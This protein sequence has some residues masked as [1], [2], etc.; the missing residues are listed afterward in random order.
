[1]SRRKLIWK[2]LPSYLS[3]VAIT[4]AVMLW[5]ANRT[6]RSLI[7]D[8][9]RAE[10]FEMGGLIRTG[11]L[12]ANRKGGME[13]LKAELVRQ[14]EA[15]ENIR[16]TV[17]LPSGRVILDTY[18]DVEM[19]DNHANRPEIQAAF[20]GQVG[21]EIRYSNT[22]KQEMLYV[23]LPCMESGH[24]LAVCRLS[25]PLALIARTRHDAF[26]RI[27]WGAFAAALVA[28]CF[29]LWISRHITAPIQEMQRVAARLAEGEFSAR[30]RLP[31]TRELAAL[32]GTMNTMAAELS[33]RIQTVTRQHNEL[34]ALLTSMVEG[35]LA[36]DDETRILIMNHAAAGML[37][38]TPETVIG[39]SIHETIRY[40]GLH[41]IFQSAIKTQSPAEGEITLQLDEAEIV[42]QVHAS[43]LAIPV[44]DRDGNRRGV[45]L[46][47]NDI[48]R[49]KRLENLRRDFA[50]NVSHELRTPI[51]SIKGFVETLRDGAMHDPEAAGRF[52]DIILAQTDRLNALISD[53]LSLAEIEQDTGNR[54]AELKTM[55][56]RPRLEAAIQAR[57]RKAEEAEITV[58]LTCPEELVATLNPV[59]FEQAV[60]NLIGNAIAYSDRGSA[61]SVTVE[62]GTDGIRIAV[63]DHGCGIEA[64]HIDRLFER[65]YRVDKHRSREKGGTGLGLAIVK[66]VVQLHKG[67]VEVDST[68]GKGSTF[69][70]ILPLP[71]ASQ[72]PENGSG[73]PRSEA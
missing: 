67:R 50:A 63:K 34:D 1:M 24:L 2:I 55:E 19:M 41:R 65:F 32:A 23:A 40:P 66:H 3:I 8:M 58:S 15:L 72:Y 16:V 28:A 21:Q 45:V 44:D 69:T 25:R 9:A 46:V 7:R 62:K 5:Q 29:S 33:E 10:L 52:L 18:H 56:L 35:V 57:K 37:G 48:T 4:V 51:T 43:P 61:V 14:L 22:L 71:S 11:L 53:L 27:A 13:N 60:A 64:E 73:A 38:V 42:L 70:I 59:L 49:L 30:L 31:E 6:T 47:L 68:P 54:K 36:V 26:V 12:E 20:T 17:I 39:Q